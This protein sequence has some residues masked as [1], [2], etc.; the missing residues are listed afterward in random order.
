VGVIF[1]EASLFPWLSTLDN[2][3][4]PLSLRGTPREERRRR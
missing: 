2:I 1:Q 3:E 4:F